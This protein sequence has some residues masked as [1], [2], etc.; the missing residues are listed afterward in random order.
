MLIQQIILE[1][2]LINDFPY[3][4]N[5]LGGMSK[6]NFIKIYL[7]SRFRYNDENGVLFAE[8]RKEQ[9]AIKFINVQGE[10]IDKLEISN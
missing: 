7:G 5:G 10:I 6:Y 9:I 3:I 1:R 2:L 4:I 8:A